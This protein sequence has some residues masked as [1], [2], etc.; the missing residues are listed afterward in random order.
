MSQNPRRRRYPV[1][2]SVQK[3]QLSHPSRE[4]VGISDHPVDFSCM[5]A[6]I[7]YNGIR[8][9]NGIM[10]MVRIAQAIGTISLLL[11]AVLLTF[12]VLENRRTT[13]LSP[14]TLTVTERFRQTAPPE[15]EDDVGPTSPLVQQAIA[16]SLYL[17][18]P[19]ASPLSQASGRT[20]AAV[21][22]WGT[23]QDAE[24]ETLSSPRPAASAPKFE[25][26][27]ISY[28]RAD[29]RLS[30][31]MIYEPGGTRRWVRSGDQVGHLVIERI[32]SD[33][34]VCRDGTQSQT[35]ALATDETIQRFVSQAGLGKQAPKPPRTPIQDA[36]APMPVRGLRQIPLSR[37]A[38]KL[39]HA[40]TDSALADGDSVEAR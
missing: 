5:D 25:L 27:G 20:V 13:P 3:R 2:F 8:S 14:G 32:E 9:W 34:L 28:Y 10:H 24:P 7:H 15:R 1:P 30:M 18:P 21:A 22:D 38:A 29:P 12:C 6:G 4:R 39:G 40:P 11:A 19:P 36:P 33:G 23:K 37:V 26:H 16:F 35:V 17:N 31:A